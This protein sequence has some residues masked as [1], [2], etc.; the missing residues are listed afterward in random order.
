M[1]GTIRETL[2]FILFWL[3][4]MA[5][6]V[7]V[8]W[9]FLSAPARRNERARLF[10][11]LLETG[12]QEGQSPERTIVSISET[13]DGSVG[14]YFHLL[15][16]H[17]EEGLRLHLAL[18]RTPN[19]LPPS[20]AAA[21]KIG[22]AEGTLDKMLPA[23]RG[24]LDDVNSR[25]RSALNHLV[26]FALVIVPTALFLMPLLS[27]YVWPRFAFILTEM[28]VTPPAFTAMVFANMGW[29]TLIEGVIL[30]GLFSLGFFY[31]GGPRISLI[32]TKIFGSLPDRFILWLP[33][34]RN[35]VH[36]DFTAALA[37]LLDAGVTENRAV[38]LAAQASANRL[39]Q[40]R[41]RKVIARLKEGMALPEA[42]KAIEQDREFQW[43]WAN[44]LRSGRAFFDALRGWHEALEAR[45]FQQ[46]QAAAQ[47]I[48]TGIVLVNGA[49]VAVIVS[50]VFL[51]LIA[52]I[53]EGVLW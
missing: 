10:L 1:T 13:R 34:R 51:M 17:I 11:D 50:A 44:A 18:E 25:M 42:L 52:I 24:M 33:W 37:V 47:T 27:Q 3:A 43:R 21:V 2:F 20:V 8:C 48:T 15:A 32:A 35:R 41:A 38:E 39:F 40:S 30:L 36:R 29:A 6:T 31:V 19:L 46:E 23:A 45:A 7:G 5:V 26:L 9:Y 14:V 49:L 12:L 4:P 16:A 22:S 53:D 28:E